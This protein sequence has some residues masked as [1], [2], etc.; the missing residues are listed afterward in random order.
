[1]NKWRNQDFGSRL[2]DL[3]KIRWPRSTCIQQEW[4]G[5]W[6]PEGTCILQRCIS[7]GINTRAMQSSAAEAANTP[8]HANSSHSIRKVGA[9]SFLSCNPLEN[10]SFGPKIEESVG[11]LIK[12]VMFLGFSTMDFVPLNSSLSSASESKMRLLG[13]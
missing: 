4:A 12:I 7:S 3:V 11:V 1:M 10:Y 8:G 9:S 5:R 6:R 2:G 13:T